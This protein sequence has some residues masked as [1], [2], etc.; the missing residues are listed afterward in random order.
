[1]M[2][3]V[4]EFGDLKSRA[5]LDCLVAANEIDRQTAHRPRDLAQAPAAI[6]VER[7]E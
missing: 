3:T 1:M 7:R 5:V 6:R 2:R 4:R